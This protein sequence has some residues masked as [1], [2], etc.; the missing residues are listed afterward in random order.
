M[1]YVVLCGYEW[2]CSTCYEWFELFG[3]LCFEWLWVVM[4]G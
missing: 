2:L 4:S 3:W 1:V